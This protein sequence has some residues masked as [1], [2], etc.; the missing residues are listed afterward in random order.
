MIKLG[1][2]GGLGYGLAQDMVTLLQGNRLAYVDWGL[3][4]TGLRGRGYS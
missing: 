3:R 4:V 1:F 2:V